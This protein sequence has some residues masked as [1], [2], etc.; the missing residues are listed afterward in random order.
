MI[1]WLV[2]KVYES[3]FLAS[4]TGVRRAH[5]L[6]KTMLTILVVYSVSRGL[7]PSIIALLVLVALMYLGG[8]KSSIKSM[9]IVSS[10]PALWLSI[11]GWL[12]AYITT[13]DTSPIALFSIYVRSLTFSLAILFLL[14]SLSPY[15]LSRIMWLTGL[16]KY[17]IA[18]LLLW[19]LTPVMLKDVV[20]AYSVQRVKGE[21]LWKSIAI[22]TAAMLE[23]RKFL[24]EY[25]YFKLSCKLLRPIPY[26]YR[27]NYT[28]ITVVAG[29]AIL[30]ACLIL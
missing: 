22:S 16:G 7:I 29:L 4:N 12:T 10:I 14:A 20:D 26:D 24:V 6:A 2:N 11:S 28:V 5:I 23:H 8:L 21:K 27:L 15:E 18:P 19:R 13:H 1:G 17:S 30:V 25:S 9:L 3:L